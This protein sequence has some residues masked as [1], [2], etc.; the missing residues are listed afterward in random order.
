MIY[1]LEKAAERRQKQAKEQA[2]LESLE[3]SLRAAWNRYLEADAKYKEVYDRFHKPELEARQARERVEALEAKIQTLLTPRG[4]IAAGKLEEYQDT[5]ELLEAA[6][7]DLR[8]ANAL[9]ANTSEYQMIRASNVRDEAYAKYMY[10]RRQLDRAIGPTQPIRTA[11][12]AQ[13]TRYVYPMN[14]QPVNTQP[15][16]WAARTA[17]WQG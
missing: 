16:P 12:P 1:A 3:L 5:H 10:T 9:T 15:A 8:K 13:Q 14:T 17:A 4:A 11:Q 6:K 7:A 2:K